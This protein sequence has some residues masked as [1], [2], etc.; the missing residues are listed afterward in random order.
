MLRLR[1]NCGITCSVFPWG[2]LFWQKVRT[3]TMHGGHI[4]AGTASVP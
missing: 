1:V 3:G 2:A 4:K